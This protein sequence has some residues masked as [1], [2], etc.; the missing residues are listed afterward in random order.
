MTIA[1]PKN[2]K[3]LDTVGIVR[4]IH[5]AAADCFDRQDPDQD[6][7]G[8]HHQEGIHWKDPRV[9]D[10]FNVAISGSMLKITYHTPCH[11]KDL[12]RGFEQKIDGTF[13]NIVKYLKKKFKQETGKTLRLKDTGD[14]HIRAESVSAVRT[15]AIACRYY[16]IMNIQ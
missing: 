14:L 5:Q 6:K 15:W 9:I 13:D 16:Q 2:K 10:G 3:E 7:A 8:L 12:K 11:I 1:M 4:A